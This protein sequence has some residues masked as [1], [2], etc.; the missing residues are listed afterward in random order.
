MIEIAPIIEIKPN[1]TIKF[2]NNTGNIETG[3]VVYPVGFFT[4]IT[5][6]TNSL[7]VVFR[8]DGGR[9]FPLVMPVNIIKQPTNI[10]S[11]NIQVGG[12]ENE[13]KILITDNAINITSPNTEINGNLKVTGNA[14]ITGNAT[15]ANKDFLNHTH[16]GVSSGS[17][18]SGP[19]S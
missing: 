5:I 7:V 16:S 3:Q 8:V 14:I 6:T 11:G 4:N 15:I 1:G 2:K 12:V 13:T 10:A 9:D 17:A 19:V 18:N